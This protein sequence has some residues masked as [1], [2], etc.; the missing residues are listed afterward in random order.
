MKRIRHTLGIALLLVASLGLQPSMSF[1][2][3]ST[4]APPTHASGYCW[5]YLLG[6]WY[7]I[8]C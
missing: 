3:S 7:A 5:I 6:R 1:A 4:V 8:P 2:A